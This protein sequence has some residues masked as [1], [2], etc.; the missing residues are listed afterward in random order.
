[1]AVY[2]A[3]N[4][5]CISGTGFPSY[6]DVYTQ[7]GIYNLK[8]YFVGSVNG[9]YLFYSNSGYWC[10]SDTLDASPCF[11]Q[12]KY[13]YDGVCPDL[14]FA[15][16]SASV[17]PTP[18][19]T[20][21]VNCDNFN[22]EG[23]FF[24]N[25]PPP[26]TP[27]PTATYTPSPTPTP[28]STNFCPNISVNA[29]ISA[30]T[31]TQTPTPSVTPT[32]IVYR[33]RS[34][35]IQCNFSGDVTFITVDSTI[36]CP[37]SKQFQDCS[38]GFMYYTTNELQNPS[39][40]EITQFMIFNAIVNGISK[41]I[42][43]LGNNSSYIGS[44]NI[45]LVT[46]PIGYSNLGG[47]SLCTVES[48]PTPTPTPTMTMTPSGGVLLSLCSVLLKSNTSVYSFSVD[49]VETL[50]PVSNVPNWTDIAHTSNKL[51]ISTS[52]KIREW[53]ITLSPFSSTFVR[54]ISNSVN[55]ITLSAGLFAISDTKLVTSNV[56]IGV[57]PITIIEINLPSST[58]TT[59]TSGNYVEM[60]DLPSDRTNTD[61]ILITTDSK[62]L[63]TNRSTNGNYYLTQFS[64]P[65]GNLELD[66]QISPT[67]SNS[68]SIFI[69]GGVIY[70]IDGP[71]QYVYSIDTTYPYNLTLIT[72]PSFSVA[73]AS[74]ILSCNN[75]SFEYNPVTYF[76]YKLCNDTEGPQSYIYQTSF[77]GNVTIGRCFKNLID[78]SCWQYEGITTTL[79]INSTDDITTFNGNFFETISSTIYNNCSQCSAVEECNPPE[80]LT[81]YYF[82]YSYNVNLGPSNYF[83]QSENEICDLLYSL[84]D[85]AQIEPY[86]FS[87]Q[88]VKLVS[89]EVGSYVYLNTVN[90]NCYGD[91]FYVYRPFFTT[92]YTIIEVYNCLIVNLWP[93]NPSMGTSPS[94]PNGIN[95]LT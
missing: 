42:T 87:S 37:V 68:A 26:E 61:D 71:S 73:G 30:I 76:K 33:N 78:N 10:L 58:S 1:M 2:C 93:C 24:V 12:G 35:Q 62:L 92:D 67:I 4:D 82:S 49:S 91:G 56:E 44:D 7:A 6:D 64:Y 54:E 69:E 57:Y 8:D 41:C 20:P 66:I 17:C 9:Y 15:Y 60:F 81:T 13:P 25:V 5:Y 95:P 52:N 75:V 55:T 38:N 11:L 45:T 36:T 22:F 85:D 80:N 18:T 39:S 83:P 51:F 23:R 29:T 86:G 50:L 47:C 65:D 16:V 21:T 94:N 77:I 48:T 27:T 84:Y 40:G 34:G 59:L 88:P 43:Y 63:V 19:P 72:A 70:L 74:T 89:L 31:P 28:T 46:G 32:I 14:T 79:P 3:N 53:N 90:C